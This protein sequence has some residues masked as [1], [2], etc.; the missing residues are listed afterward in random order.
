MPGQICDLLSQQPNDV[1]VAWCHWSRMPERM[2]LGPAWPWRLKPDNDGAHYAVHGTPRLCSG[3][4]M[5]A[6]CSGL[7]TADCAWRIAHRPLL[8]HVGGRWEG[9]WRV[10]R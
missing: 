6:H 8:C 2:S 5:S 4:S 9:F 3:L 7:R 10:L 1:A